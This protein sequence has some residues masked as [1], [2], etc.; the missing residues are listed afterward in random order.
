MPTIKSFEDLEIW[1]QSRSLV[2]A[3]YSDF[4]KCKDF[5]FRDQVTRAAISIMNNIA[6]G[7]SRS[8]DSEFRHFLNI[9]RG[10]AGE[11]K[12]MYYAAEDLKFIPKETASLRRA[13]A[14]KLMNGLGIFIQYLRKSNQ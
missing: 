1:Q 12:S 2:F 13:Q 7:F 11:V 14:Q 4:S 9:A 8:S 10:S 6:E 3:V 5:G